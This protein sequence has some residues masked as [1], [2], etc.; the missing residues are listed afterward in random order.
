[1]EQGLIF[2]FSF[3]KEGLVLLRKM[4]IRKRWLFF[5]GIEIVFLAMVISFVSLIL[6]SAPYLF[7]IWFLS[8]PIFFSIIV[9]CPKCNSS[10]FSI[11][12]SESSVTSRLR[13]GRLLILFWKTPL[14][15]EVLCPV[16]HHDLFESSPDE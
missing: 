14:K 4:N 7:P 13:F 9:K 12:K 11:I 2:K 5:I 6:S 3:L 10:F 16:C 15:G 1:M 8:F